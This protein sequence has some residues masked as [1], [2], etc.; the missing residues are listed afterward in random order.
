MRGVKGD[1]WWTRSK[2]ETK[3]AGAILRE[4]GALRFHFSSVSDVSEDP[5][6]DDRGSD[7]RSAERGLW[8]AK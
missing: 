1:R 8:V 7:V 4:K 2:Q 3:I 6:T 5:P